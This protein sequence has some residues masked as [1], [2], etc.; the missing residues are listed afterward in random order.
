MEHRGGYEQAPTD[1][2]IVATALQAISSQN[3]F[4]DAPPTYDEA[5]VGYDKTFTG[6]NK[7]HDQ[8]ELDYANVDQGVV[9]FFFI[10]SKHSLIL[11]RS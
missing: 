4:Q 5:V 2:V 3:E 1:N 9:F 8:N 7:L 10:A 6:D 11:L